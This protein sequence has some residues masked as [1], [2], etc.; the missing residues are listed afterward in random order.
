MLDGESLVGLDSGAAIVGSRHGQSEGASEHASDGVSW[1]RRK[2]IPKDERRGTTME[3]LKVQQRE[4][5]RVQK[6]VC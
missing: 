1:N 3:S 2:S 5:Q 6:M 4:G